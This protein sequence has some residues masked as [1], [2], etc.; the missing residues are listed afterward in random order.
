VKP[1]LCRFHSASNRRSYGRSSTNCC[2]ALVTSPI[3]PRGI[4]AR[5][6]AG[7]PAAGEAA[8]AI[9]ALVAPSALAAGA[10]LSDCVLEDGKNLEHLV[11]LHGWAE[12]WW[13][14]LDGEVEVM[15]E[16]L[17]GSLRIGNVMSWLSKI[18]SVF[19]RRLN[20]FKYPCLAILQP[21]WKQQ[22]AL[23]DIQILCPTRP[24]CVCFAARTNLYNFESTKVVICG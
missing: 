3:R 17:R 5:G 21:N 4:A 12:D 8:A 6:D 16:L 24:S 14:G 18:Q 7:V 13:R 9:L 2:T 22:L 1:S 20:L 15:S 11:G 10:D 23:V 19:Y